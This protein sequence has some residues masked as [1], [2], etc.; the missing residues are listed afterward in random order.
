MLASNLLIL[1]RVMLRNS[2]LSRV[3]SD[4]STLSLFNVNDAGR[5]MIR[6]IFSAI[7][8][9]RQFSFHMEILRLLA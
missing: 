1:G 5:G 9:D 6:G 8:H 2:G 4:E 3:M 7:N